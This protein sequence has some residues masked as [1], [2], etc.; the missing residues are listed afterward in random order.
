M[1]IKYVDGH[2]QHLKLLTLHHFAR[3]QGSSA[4]LVQY[5]YEK[6]IKRTRTAIKITEI[7]KFRGLNHDTLACTKSFPSV[8][9]TF[10]NLFNYLEVRAKKT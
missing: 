6:Y 4:C 10:A 5:I 9:V 7:Q 1:F 8:L 2:G 3:F